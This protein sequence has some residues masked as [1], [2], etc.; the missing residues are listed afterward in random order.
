MFTYN[1]THSHTIDLRLS[2][3][4]KTQKSKAHTQ[5]YTEKQAGMHKQ[6]LLRKALPCFPLLTASPL[7]LSCCSHPHSLSRWKRR[8]I[9]LPVKK[10]NDWNYN[11][12]ISLPLSLLSPFS[13]C[14]YSLT[15]PFSVISTCHPPIYFINASKLK[16]NTYILTHIVSLK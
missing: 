13:Q 12:K 3:M 8:G 6:K 1:Y 5:R 9:L 2:N 7:S 10:V 11:I 15:I 14:L 16:H 4:Y